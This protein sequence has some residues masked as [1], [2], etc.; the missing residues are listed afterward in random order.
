MLELKDAYEILGIKEG[1]GKDEIIKRYNLLLKKHRLNS[2][3]DSEGAASGAAIQEINRAYNLL[4]GYGDKGQA[5]EEASPKST[6]LSPLFKK[7]GIDEKKARNFFYYHK[8]HI[9]AAIVIVVIIGSFVSSIVNNVEPDLN[10]IIAGEIQVNDIDAMKETII[11]TLPNI[12]EVS[13]D[14]IF[15]SSDPKSQIDLSMKTKFI[16]LIAAGDLDVLILDRTN[17]EDLGKKGAFLDLDYLADQKVIDKETNKK[18]IL[19]EEESGE[20]H[21]YGIDVTNSPLLK[22]IDTQGKELIAVIRANCKH[23]ENSLSFIKLLVR[24]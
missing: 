13:I 20:E 19:K 17:F 4:M 2:N 11:N 16:T 18:N 10:I 12:K 3:D 5:Q 1:A 22:N 23:Y 7:A 21:L 9:L 6:I 24:S 14:P 8:F 15:L